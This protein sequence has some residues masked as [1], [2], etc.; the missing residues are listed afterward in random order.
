MLIYMP[1]LNWIGKE[2]VVRHHL[3][4][5]YRLLVPV[6][7]L[8][9]REGDNLLVEGDNLEA[10][11]A[12]LPEYRG[13]VKLVY[14]DPPYNTG[15]ESWIYNDN[16]NSPEIRAWLGKVVG[17]EAEDL[18]RHDKWLSMMYPRLRLLWELLREDGI[19]LVSIDD[20]EIGR[21]RGIADEIFGPTNFVT[22]FIWVNEG[23]TE[24]QSQIISKHEYILVYAKNSNLFTIN[25]VKDPNLPEGSKVNKPFIENSV[26]KNGP[27]N[28]VSII[29]L[30]VGFPSIE[31]A[32]EIPVPQ[33]AEELLASIDKSGGYISK[34]L[35]KQFQARYP[36]NL[37][38]IKVAHGRL[39]EPVRVYSGWQNKRKLEE[40]IANR[41]EPINDENG[42]P[43]EFFLTRTGAI[44]YRKKR[45]E[46]PYVTTVLRGMGTT[47]KNRNMLLKLGIDFPYPKPL[48][49]I[50]FLIAAFS[51]GSDIILDSFAGSGTTGHAVLKQNAQDGGNRRFILVELDPNI[52]Q[53]IARKRLEHAAEEHGDGFRYL[54]LGEPLF[55]P[56][57]RIREGVDYATL[58]RYIY[59]RETG[60]AL[61]GEVAGPLLGVS[62]RGV[63]VYLLYNG[64]L[65]DRSPGGGNVL[66][67]K[68]LAHLPSH[69]GPRVVYG[70]ACRLSPRTL[71]S[72][73]I[74]FRHIPYEVAS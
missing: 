3:A 19:F 36:V 9:Y 20:G 43:M 18:S 72:L 51:S 39:S 73:G 24:N 56:D 68:T 40:F 8:S 54:R 61:L 10:L 28:P 17:K 42:M 5:P 12:L 50:Q 11:K 47:E 37:D 46:K 35:T 23:N 66:T 69:A 25:S 64:V 74:T 59:Y 45:P 31:D 32:L 38:P 6:P 33:Y 65:K 67:R 14:I 27:K 30:P 70:T 21:L 53:N 29:T 22:T 44:Y 55:L 58:A 48:E 26:V 4:V 71:E 15:K 1:A 49:L 16:V 57:G 62:S 52:A 63:A 2:A 7:E 34:L 60:E 13:R 41:C